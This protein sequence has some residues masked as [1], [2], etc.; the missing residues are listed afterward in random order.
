[1][2]YPVLG[3]AL[4]LADPL[5]GRLAQQ[6]GTKPGLATAVTVN[7]L[8]PLAAVAFGITHA[9]VANAWLGAVLMTAGLIVGLAAQ[10]ARGGVASPVEVLSAVPPVL[11]VAA[12]GYAILGTVAALVTTRYCRP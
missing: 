6:L 4:G 5:L 1:M 8:L 3:L 10:Y 12:V 2:A 7:L 11:V 9:R